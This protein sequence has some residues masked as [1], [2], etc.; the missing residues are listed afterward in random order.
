MCGSGTTLKM[1]KKHNR[2]FIGCDI[3][4]EY[5]DIAKMRLEKYRPQL[6]LF[7]DK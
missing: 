6:T 2:L 3:S 5:V 1:A 7:A 4:M